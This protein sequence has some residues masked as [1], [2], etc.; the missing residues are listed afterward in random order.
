MDVILDVAFVI[1]VTAFFREQFGLKG[2]AVIGVAFL[3]TLIIGY[4]PLVSEL[5][6]NIAPWLRVLVGT[7]SLFLAAAGSWDAAVA[8]IGSKKVD[9]RPG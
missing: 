8:L 3:V 7:F 9:S 2:K 6:P 4:V 5:F 1:A